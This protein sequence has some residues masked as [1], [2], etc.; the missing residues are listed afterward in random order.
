MRGRV[1]V[2]ALALALALAG[3]A[4]SEPT[5]TASGPVAD[6]PSAPASATPSASPTGTPSAAS[7]SLALG[8]CTGDVDLSGGQHPT[9]ECGNRVVRRDVERLEAGVEALATQSLRFS[10]PLLG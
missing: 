8:E 7:P 9:G 3:C 2:A 10:A 6:S 1:A 4:T 5:P